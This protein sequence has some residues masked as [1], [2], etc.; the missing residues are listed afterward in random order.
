MKRF[1]DSST[2]HREVFTRLRPQIVSSHD[3]DQRPWTSQLVEH[4]TGG[5]VV[6]GLEGTRSYG[7]GLARA[8]QAAGL[9]VIEVEHPKRS[10]RRRGKSDPIDA[11]LAI[12][13]TEAGRAP[14]LHPAC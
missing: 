11:R 13:H 9:V 10:D 3:L 14:S 8:L 5:Q 7:I 6:V 4:A 12:L 1:L 2:P